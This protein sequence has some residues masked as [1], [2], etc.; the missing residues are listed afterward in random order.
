MRPRWCI[1]EK[2]LPSAERVGEIA[3]GNDDVLGHLP[4]ELLEDLE[5]RGLLAF[6]P[7]GIDR[8]E[9]IDGKARD[10]LGE[11]AD[12]AV[13]VGLELDGERAVVHRLRELAP[14]D[15][16]F[17]DEDDAAQ[18]GAGGI[19]GHGGR[20][21]AGGGAGDPLEAALGGD[22]ER[23]GHAGVLEGAGGIHA[24]VLG[25]QPVDADGLGAARQVVERRVAFAQGDDIRRGL[26]RWEAGRGSARRRS[27]RRAW[28]RC[29]APA[30]ASGGR[31][32]WADCCRRRQ[33]AVG[34]CA[35]RDR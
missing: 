6:E 31:W 26:R 5:G 11:D 18:A 12:A 10:Q 30:R 7:V 32:H 1:S 16:A 21:V 4:V 3:A 29:G 34:D 23:G 33:V 17:G 25:E 20:G 15:L 24:L 14:G 22:G 35:T 8:V 28:W 27:G 19:G 2:P 13:E 9:Q